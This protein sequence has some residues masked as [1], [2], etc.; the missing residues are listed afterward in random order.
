MTPP[1]PSPQLKCN[2]SNRYLQKLFLICCIEYSL[3]S[4][5]QQFLSLHMVHIM[6]CRVACHTMVPKYSVLIAKS[7]LSP[8]CNS[9]YWCMGCGCKTFLK[10]YKINDP[11]SCKMLVL[12]ILICI[13]LLFLDTQLSYGIYNFFFSRFKIPTLLTL[14]CLIFTLKFITWFRRRSS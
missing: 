8:K 3:F 2:Y 7:K 13:L 9:K 1:P 14:R 12:A 6:Q 5:A 11:V 4:K 10:K